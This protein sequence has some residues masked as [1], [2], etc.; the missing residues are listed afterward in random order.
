MRKWI[1]HQKTFRCI[2]PFQF[3]T[4]VTLIG[5]VVVA[6]IAIVI[7]A[8]MIISSS[9]GPKNGPISVKT[10][11]IY[12]TSS[13][14]GASVYIDGSSYKKG[15]N[16]IKITGV[17]ARSQTIKLSEVGYDDY[18]SRRYVK[19]GETISIYAK[20]TRL[21]PVGIRKDKKG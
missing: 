15:T 3:F 8:V 18:T 9:V 6:G 12:V 19:A 10:G 4:F 16:P 20:L 17:S 13:P 1:C 21:K 2:D 5:V 7:L 11:S 14:S